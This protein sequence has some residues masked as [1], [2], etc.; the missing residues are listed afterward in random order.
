M[1]T[2]IFG[3][4]R[5][6]CEER[7]IAAIRRRREEGRQK[8]GKSMDRKDLSV[9]DWIKHAQEEAMDLAIY[10]ERVKEGVEAIMLSDSAV[11]EQVRVD[12]YVDASMSAGGEHRYVACMYFLDNNHTKTPNHIVCERVQDE[13]STVHTEEIAILTAVT[14]MPD[15]MRSHKIT[16]HSD[17]L[18]S[19]QRVDR[20]ILPKLKL[21]VSMQLTRGA[22]NS[23]DGHEI[24]HYSVH[25][26]VKSTMLGAV[27]WGGGNENS[28]QEGTT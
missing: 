17:H 25:K 18:P 20:H 7:V 28:K 5:D 9:L 26:L 3:G 1:S 2:D 23:T 19:I 15:A 21:N 22:G 11:S 4:N 8:Y 24:R 14:H 10:L 13:E 12:V 16:I 6:G 27:V